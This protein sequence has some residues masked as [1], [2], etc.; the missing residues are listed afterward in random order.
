MPDEVIDN[1]ALMKALTDV[2]KGFVALQAKVDAM[3]APRARRRRDVVDEEHADRINAD[4]G[5]SQRVLDNARRASN[6]AATALERIRAARGE[7]QPIARGRHVV[8]GLPGGRQIIT[9]EHVEHQQAFHAWFRTGRGENELKASAIKASLQT[10]SDPDGG[11]VVP[12]TM[13]T[14]IDR[15][16]AK[17]STVRTLA[18]VIQISTMNYKKPVNLGGATVGW[19]SETA[20]RPTTNTPTLSELDFPAME[21]YANPASTQALLDDASINI[22]SWLADEVAIKFAEQEG[23]AFVSGTGV[24]QPRGFESYTN[25]LDASYVWGSIGYV[26][27][28]VAAD[29]AATNP[30]DQLLDMVYTLKR[31]YRINA[32]YLCNDP[33]LAKIRKFKDTT[34]QYLWQPPIQLGQPSSLNGYPIES[35]DNMPS[36]GANNFPV[37][38]ADWNQAYLII[39]RIGIRVLR[40][41]FTNKPYVNFYT[42]KRVGGGIQNFEAIKLLKCEV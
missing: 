20:A 14:T 17:Y 35:D 11:F 10:Q 39:D 13:E 1:A 33:T 18:R 4:V 40:D 21:E 12:F 23:T 31:G 26:K 36:V 15:V 32:N 24:G 25:V 38:F 34:G 22:E 2:N 6:S 5:R 28:G 37:A 8:P 29:F 19:V 3:D 42:T 27:T 7:R 9:A 41:P 30:N 16:L